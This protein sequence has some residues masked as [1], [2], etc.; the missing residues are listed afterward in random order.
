[1]ISTHVHLNFKPIVFSS[2][3]QRVYTHTHN[4]IK[5]NGEIA[6]TFHNSIKS[7]YQNLANFGCRGNVH[8]N[9]KIAGTFIR[10]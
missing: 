2:S 6:R 10:I 1:M 3:V 4:K 8:V 7:S 5:K 9:M